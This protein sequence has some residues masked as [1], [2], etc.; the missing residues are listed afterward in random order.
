M[1]V[2][3]ISRAEIDALP[4]GDIVAVDNPLTFD[5]PPP[6]RSPGMVITLDHQYTIKISGLGHV[7]SSH[8]HGHAQ[9][10]PHMQVRLDVE[11]S[12]NRLKQR[13]IHIPVDTAREL[14][15]AL[16]AAAEIAESQAFRKL[17]ELKAVLP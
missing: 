9:H 7:Q 11:D 17:K 12:G 10:E 15:G 3:T 2:A 16:Q 5:M 6:R 14:A 13:Q 4:D 1:A 8:T